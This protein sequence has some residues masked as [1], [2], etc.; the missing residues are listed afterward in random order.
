MLGSL[1]KGSLL[2]RLLPYETKRASKEIAS[3]LSS[4]SIRSVPIKPW[5]ISISSI[6]AQ[7]CSYLFIVQS[8]IFEDP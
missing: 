1:G 6:C 3:K 5:F 7:Y 2:N 8:I 4:K